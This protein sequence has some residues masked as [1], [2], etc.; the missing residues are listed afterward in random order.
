VKAIILNRRDWREYDQL[1]SLYTKHYGK[2]EALA[3][4]VKKIISKNS[5]H[6]EPFSLVRVEVIKGKMVD[7]LTKVQ[8]LYYYKKIREDFFKSMCAVYVVNILDKLTRPDERQ[9]ELFNLTKS[10][11][12]YIEQNKCSEVLVVAWLSRAMIFLGFTPEIAVCAQ[13]SKQMEGEMNWFAE[14]GGVLC[15]VCAQGKELTVTNVPELISL[16]S[17]NWGDLPEEV[18]LETENFLYNF[19]IYHSEQNIPRLTLFLNSDMLEVDMKKVINNN[20]NNN[21]S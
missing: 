1:V 11:L 14:G 16:W 8:S 6:I 9:V 15:G 3:R 4:G 20:N 13:C 17:N 18:S 12:D 5:A 2:K 21:P 7:H 19:L 10:F